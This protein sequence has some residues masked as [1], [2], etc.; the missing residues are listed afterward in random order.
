M[1]NSAF[2]GPRSWSRRAQFY[3]RFRADDKAMMDILGTQ[4]NRK[5]IETLLHEITGNDW[6]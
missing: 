5:L 4:A 2:S 6:T 3:T 1:R